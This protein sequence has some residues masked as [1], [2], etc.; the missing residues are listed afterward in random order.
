MFAALI[1][2]L[3]NYKANLEAKSDAVRARCDELR[4]IVYENEEN[5]IFYPEK[6]SEYWQLEN[7]ADDLDNEAWN[8]L[9]VLNMFRDLANRNLTESDPA[10]IVEV[11]SGYL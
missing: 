8:T 10:E 3:E 1:Q 4:E 11:I 2:S 5:R 9:Q 6:D 7:V